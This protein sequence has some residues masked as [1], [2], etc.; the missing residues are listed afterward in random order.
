MGRKPKRSAKPTRHATE[1]ER[2]KGRSKARQAMRPEGSGPPSTPS[3]EDPPVRERSDPET[4]RSEAMAAPDPSAVVVPDPFE[5][6]T[7]PQRQV[8][9]ARGVVRPLRTYHESTRR[10]M[11]VAALGPEVRTYRLPSG[12]AV[13]VRTVMEMQR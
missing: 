5:W 1:K 2:V 8:D 7:R 13:E 10:N 4:L 12:R 6:I 9:E 3:T 11:T